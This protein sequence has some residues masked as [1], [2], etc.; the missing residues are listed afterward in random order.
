MKE[1]KILGKAGYWYRVTGLE[2]C[3]DC[4]LCHQK[5]YKVIFK[6][7]E[8]RVYL[9]TWRDEE[10]TKRNRKGRKVKLVSKE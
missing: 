6:N 9:R 2:T 8:A 3:C 5:E 7:G 1:K 4:G 10:R